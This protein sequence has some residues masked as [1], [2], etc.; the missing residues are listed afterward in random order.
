MGEELG[1]GTRLVIV[2]A[3]TLSDATREIYQNAFDL[4]IID[5]MLPRRPGALATDISSDLLEILEQSERNRNT[6]AIAL[7]AFA[8]LISDQIRAFN[9]HGIPI[10]YFD[11]SNNTWRHNL[12]RELRLLVSAS[13]FDFVIICALEKERQAYRKT[14]ATCGD[15]RTIRGL[16]CLELSFNGMRGVVVK[17]P[18]MGMIDAAVTATRAIDEF[19]PRFLGMSG[20]CAGIPGEMEIGD[21]AIVE[22]CFDYQVGKWTAKGFEFELYQ[23]SISESSRAMISRLIAGGELAFLR[24][25]LGF[26]ELNTRA[27]KLVT[28]ASGSSVVADAARRAEIVKQHRKLA[29]IEMEIFSIYRAAALSTIQPGF[30]AVKGVVDGAGKSKGDKYHNYGAITSARL[31]LEILSLAISR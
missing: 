20:I 3:A 12:Q 29:S 11:F 24:E 8:D 22:N 7:T 2:R 26:P 28:H 30:V 1:S 31:L 13:L 4:V 14:S 18:R 27:L 23:S 15:V 5:L 25:G 10:I 6:R 21:I 9:E 16:D 19:K 17:Q